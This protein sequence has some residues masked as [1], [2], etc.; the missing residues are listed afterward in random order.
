[1][2]I[3]DPR[4]ALQ[5]LN[6]SDARQRSPVS[7]FAKHFLAIM[8]LFAPPE[9]Q[10]TIE[11][12]EAAVE[13]TDGRAAGNRD[14][15][16]R[17]LADEVKYCGG[18]VQK[19][20]VES[21]SQRRFIEEELPVLAIDALRRAEQCRA[22][23]RITRLARILTNASAHGSH[24][25]A[26]VVEEMMAIATELSEIDML[27]L[28]HAAEEYERESNAHRSE[29][30]YSVAGRAWDRVPTLVSAKISDDDLISAGAKLAS[31][32]LMVSVGR[33]PWEKPAYR[34]LERATTFLQYVR[35]AGMDEKVSPRG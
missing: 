23:S 19:L 20:L 30:Q 33:Q 25:G 16:V 34:P 31:F 29:A 32:G 9:A 28:S 15:F 18:Q 4:S 35:S 14:E 2:A 13:W 11:G 8:K 12:L 1:M 17:V 27:V 10:F 7:R 26:D 5:T 22:K 6:D 24:D 21:E 3:D